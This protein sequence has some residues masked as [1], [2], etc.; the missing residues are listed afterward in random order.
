MENEKETY[1][2]TKCGS[3]DVEIRVWTNANP[4]IHGKWTTLP[5]AP[6]DKSDT[7]CKACQEHN[8]LRVDSKEAIAP[9]TY[10]CLVNTE[11]L[12]ELEL[13]FEE[14]ADKEFYNLAK[15]HGQII[16]SLEEFVQAFNGSHV[17][18]DGDYLRVITIN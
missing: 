1:V 14:V 2:C 16:S 7:W 12:D 8:H 18:S 3:D 17:S 5:E 4:H 6:M 10:Y 11:Y 15:Q 9:G 13:K